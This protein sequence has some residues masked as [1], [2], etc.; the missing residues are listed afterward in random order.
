MPSCCCLTPRT[1]IGGTGRII[2]LM[3]PPSQRNTAP[4]VSGFEPLAP[5]FPSTV[6]TGCPLWATAVIIHLFVSSD[7]VPRMLKLKQQQENRHAA[8]FTRFL[9][10]FLKETTLESRKNTTMTAAFS[11]PVACI[12]EVM[13]KTAMYGKCLK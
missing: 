8:V 6:C 3:I 12:S 1:I 10:L 9:V 13:N 11:C 7:G 2:G 5:H 4:R